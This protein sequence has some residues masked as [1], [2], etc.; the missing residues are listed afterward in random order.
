MKRYP[1]S[2]RAADA[3]SE[4]RSHRQAAE[5]RLQQLT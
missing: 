2:A 1:R 5:E 3:K 4:L